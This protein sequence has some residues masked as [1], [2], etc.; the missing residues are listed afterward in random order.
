MQPLDVLDLVA[1]LR[2]GLHDHLPGAAEAIE[3]VDVPRA[4]V[5]LQ[6]VEHFAQADALRHALLAVDVDVQLRRIG[7][8]KR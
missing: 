8:C 7:S 4:Q 3:V 5:R 2:I 1:E 6:G